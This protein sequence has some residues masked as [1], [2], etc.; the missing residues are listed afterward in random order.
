MLV[1]KTLGF[2][3]YTVP[4]HMKINGKDASFPVDIAPNR[5]IIVDAIFPIDAIEKSTKGLNFSAIC[6]SLKLF[7]TRG[8][9]S[10]S[11]CPGAIE[12]SF[13]K[14]EYSANSYNV[15]ILIATHERHLGTGGLTPMNGNLYT[16]T[17]Q[18]AGIFQ[19]TPETV[20]GSC[21]LIAR[22]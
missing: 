12:M 18:R 16:A 13:T 17:A 10:V 2:V 15:A 21:T 7:D 4:T 5:P 19:L 8:Q 14:E 9:T 22:D 6:P 3:T 11:V 1:T 20:P